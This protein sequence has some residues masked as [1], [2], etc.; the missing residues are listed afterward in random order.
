MNLPAF[1]QKDGFTVKVEHAFGLDQELV[2]GTLY[3]NQHLQARGH[4]CFL[5]NTFSPH[6]PLFPSALVAKMEILIL[7]QSNA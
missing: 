4:P 2:N 3:F 1:G 7:N 6:S 5:D